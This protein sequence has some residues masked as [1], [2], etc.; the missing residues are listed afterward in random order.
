MRDG[1]TD[2]DTAHGMI[3][4]MRFVDWSGHR[5]SFAMGELYTEGIIVWMKKCGSSIELALDRML[6]NRVLSILI[7]VLAIELS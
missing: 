5:L 2:H 1:L 4:E 6:L 7:V 3:C